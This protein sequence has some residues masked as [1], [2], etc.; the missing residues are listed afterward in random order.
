MFPFPFSFIAPAADVP[1]GQIAN[2]EAMSFN[3]TDTYVAFPATPNTGD[4]SISFWVKHSTGGI[5]VIASGD[6][7]FNY[8][9]FYNLSIFNKF[10]SKRTSTTSYKYIFVIKHF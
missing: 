4:I 2:A 10:F 8:L 3:G 1:V 5:C 9:R 6:G 7:V